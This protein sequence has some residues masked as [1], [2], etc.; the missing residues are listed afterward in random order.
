MLRSW[1]KSL[2]AFEHYSSHQKRWPAEKVVMHAQTPVVPYY[3][4]YVFGGSLQVL[5]YCA[6]KVEYNKPV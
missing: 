2:S 6:F 3:A 4:L 5:Q 1:K